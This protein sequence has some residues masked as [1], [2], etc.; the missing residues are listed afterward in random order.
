MCLLS[1]AGFWD[2]MI[3]GGIN[4]LYKLRG[5]L[6]VPMDNKVTPHF[7][8]HV[9]RKMKK[10]IKYVTYMLNKCQPQNRTKYE[11]LCVVRGII[12]LKKVLLS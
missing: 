11:K 3:R 12:I 5:H 2:R 4:S 6:V 1:F 9:N 8:L 10:N 7:L